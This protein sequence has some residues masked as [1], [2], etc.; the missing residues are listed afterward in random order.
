VES[1]RP[2]ETMSL[3][4]AEANLI[5]AESVPFRFRDFADRRPLRPLDR[6]TV[7]I[8]MV[9]IYPIGKYGPGFVPRGCRCVFVDA[10]QVAT[11]QNVFSAGAKDAIKHVPD[12]YYL[13][14]VLLH[15]AG[16]LVRGDG[17]TFDG[18][19][20]EAARVFNTDVNTAKLRE[21]EADRF[22][23]LQLQDALNA[24]SPG[25]RVAAATMAQLAVQ[26]AN[27]NF[28][29]YRVETDTSIDRPIQTYFDIGYSHE[30]LELRTLRMMAILSPDRFEESVR[31]DER[32][33]ARTLR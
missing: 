17:G 21:R 30:N 15:E 4:I 29:V 20:T 3:A 25:P 14:L 12:E 33:R 1:D 9:E 28:I 22:A 7:P 24:M 10:E 8:Y 23:A 16:H 31:E 5:L 27:V 26:V 18:G 2:H 6:E 13:T 19:G 32:R 11:I